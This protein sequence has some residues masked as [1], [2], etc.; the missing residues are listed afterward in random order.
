MC[1]YKERVIIL[2]DQYRLPFPVA[3]WKFMWAECSAAT[4]YGM[5]DSRA[6]DTDVEKVK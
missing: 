2:C 4:V 5:G 6:S 3:I 1:I